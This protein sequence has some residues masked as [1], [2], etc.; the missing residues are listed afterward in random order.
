MENFTL[1]LKLLMARGELTVADTARLFDRERRT[2]SSWVRD[3]RQPTG[4]RV[5]ETFETL[6]QLE[7]EVERGR[8]F[9]IPR[10]LKKRERTAYVRLLGEG[11]L[12]RARV[13][14]AGAPPAKG[15]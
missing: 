2:V 15:R 3:G 6:R 10:R 13:L 5:A 4:A 14:A 9:P 7:V 1:R 8:G 12:G 11:K